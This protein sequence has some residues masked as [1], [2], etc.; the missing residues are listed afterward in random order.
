[1]GKTSLETLDGKRQIILRLKVETM[2]VMPPGLLTRVD[3]LQI[4]S[5][6]SG[7]IGTR[8]E[9]D[10]EIGTEE[11]KD[12]VMIGGTE[13][14]TEVGV[15]V[16]YKLCTGRRTDPEVTVTTTKTI[17]M[18]S[19][20]QGMEPL[21]ILSPLGVIAVIITSITEQTT[22]ITMIMRLVFISP[23]TINS[24]Q[25]PLVAINI[26]SVRPT[27]SRGTDL[28]TM[29]AMTATPS[30]LRRSIRR[31]RS[32]PHLAVVMSTSGGYLEVTAMMVTSH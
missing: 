23:V 14:G 2:L 29:T 26:S 24:I 11:G 20:G 9:A 19:P 5:R 27:M 30:P 28:T 1:M 3:L 17:D 25:E 31:D 18:T 4:F 15:E 16:G 8:I 22:V 6:T 12:S 32:G 21:S 10:K 7:S 13:A